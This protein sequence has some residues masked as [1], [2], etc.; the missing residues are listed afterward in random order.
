MPLMYSCC[1]VTALGAGMSPMPPAP[2]PYRRLTPSERARNPKRS[3]TIV[4]RAAARDRLG[5]RLTA[6]G[7]LRLFP[8]SRQRQALRPG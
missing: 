5:L 2:G 4:R 1:Q 7:S 6:R 3:A 8:A